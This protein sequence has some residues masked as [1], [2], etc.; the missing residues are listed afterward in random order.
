MT[1]LELLL[2]LWLHIVLEMES[3]RA[4]A[5]VNLEPIRGLQDAEGVKKCKA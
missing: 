1:D 5:S 4:Q 3:F 2:T